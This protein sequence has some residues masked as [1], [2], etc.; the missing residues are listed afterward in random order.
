MQK[1]VTIQ[2]G[3]YR[4]CDKITGQ[5]SSC[6]PIMKTVTPRVAE[7]LSERVATILS[8]CYK[9]YENTKKQKPKTTMP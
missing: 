9:E 7:A 8:D 3:S 1:S 4:L 5:F 6:Q 2:I